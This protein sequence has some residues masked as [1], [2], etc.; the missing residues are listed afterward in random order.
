MNL[1]PTKL[2]LACRAKALDLAETYHIMACFECGS[3]AYTCPAGLP[4]VQLVRTGK[5][6]LAAQK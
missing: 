6:L 4:I 5:A 1:V 3:C 2:A